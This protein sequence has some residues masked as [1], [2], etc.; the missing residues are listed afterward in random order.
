MKEKFK[1][2]DFIFKIYN[3]FCKV[4]INDQLYFL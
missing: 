1:F 3:N 2:V 4:I